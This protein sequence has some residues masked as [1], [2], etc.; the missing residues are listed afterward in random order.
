MIFID[1]ID[2]TESD[3][4]KKKFQVGDFRMWNALWVKYKKIKETYETNYSKNVC[5]HKLSCCCVGG[6]P[7]ELLLG[8]GYTPSQAQKACCC[9]VSSGT[10]FSITL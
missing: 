2:N 10:T 6:V 3:D 5:C 9:Y 4:D 7:G 1:Y 8:G